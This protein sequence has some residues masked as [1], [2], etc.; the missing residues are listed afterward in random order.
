[1]NVEEDFFDRAMRE[2]QVEVQKISESMKKVQNIY[3]DLAGLVDGQQDQIDQLEDI[4]EGVKVDTRAGLEEIQHGMWKLCTAESSSPEMG[5]N[6]DFNGNGNGNGIHQ[7]IQKHRNT[8]KKI[9][10]P[11]DILNCMM[12][13]HAPPEPKAGGPAISLDGNLYHETTISRNQ[14]N[15]NANSNANYYKDDHSVSASSSGWKL[16]KFEHVQETAQDAYNLGHAMV[17]GIVGQVHEVVASGEGLREVG[18][19]I[20]CT[21]QPEEY[22][23]SDTDNGDGDG[24]RDCDRD[25][26]VSNGIRLEDTCTA[27]GCSDENHYRG[28]GVHEER[29]C[30]HSR[31]E[32]QRKHTRSRSHQSSHKHQHQRQH[33]HGPEPWEEDDYNKASSKIERRKGRHHGLRSKVS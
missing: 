25:G 26:A 13:C 32:D 14:N 29:P 5:L 12:A 18:Y 19:R 20:S 31:R 9:L 8:K 23:S 17:G 24:D 2:R 22:S 4:N 27:K 33:Q 16:P 1:V 21:P 10:D 6:G 28:E 11:S 3:T 7:E 15:T 30:H